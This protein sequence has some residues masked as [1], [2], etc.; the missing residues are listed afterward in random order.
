MMTR[1]TPMVRGVKPSRLRK[2]NRRPTMKKP[3]RKKP[4]SRKKLMKRKRLSKRRLTK[5]KQNKKKLT[6]RRPPI[7]KRLNKKKPTRKRLRS[8]RMPMNRKRLQKTMLMTNKMRQMIR[9]RMR[10][11]V[12]KTARMVRLASK[13]NL[14][15]RQTTQA[16]LLKVRPVLSNMKVTWSSWTKRTT[17][18]GIVL[19]CPLIRVIS[20]LRDP[21]TICSC[22]RIWMETGALL[23]LTL[24]SH[25]LFTG[26]FATTLILVTAPVA[27]MT[28]LHTRRL[29]MVAVTFSHL[30]RRRP[31]SLKTCPAMILR[32]APS[33]LVFASFVPAEMSAQLM[34]LACWHS[35][36]T[37]GATRTCLA[38]QQAL[39]H[40]LQQ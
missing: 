3:R 1:L 4:P 18:F 34:R 16:H 14:W 6:R 8:N 19:I 27:T 25:L 11:R 23:A 2:N 40:T 9:L 24:R 20:L 32:M 22:L 21:S 38:I 17:L 37:S 39:S 13:K 28:P 10:K 31:M 29:R 15:V 35:P 12:E 36:L 30:S 26:I 33:R 5:S 7:K